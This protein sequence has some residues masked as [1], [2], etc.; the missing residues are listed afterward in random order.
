MGARNTATRL[1]ILLTLLSLL[2]SGS[3]WASAIGD[4]IENA[5]GRDSQAQGAVV[6]MPPASAPEVLLK[7]VR[8]SSRKQA[9]EAAFNLSVIAA[10]RG[11]L[12]SAATLIEEALLLAPENP[13]Y[14]RAAAGIAYTAGAYDRAE[15]YQL[16][17]L[18]MARSAYGP[19]DLR[20]ATL[21]DELGAVYFELNR[22][23]RTETLLRQGL[24]IREQGAGKMHP[25]L[26][27]TLNDLAGFAMQDGRFD[28]AEQLL[29]RA[30][31]ILEADAGTNLSNAAMAMHN[32]GDFY[33]NR[34]RFPEA[35]VLYRRA[36]LVWEGL[37]EEERLDVAASLNELGRFYAS[38]QRLDE[39]KPQFELV[40][41]LLS[42]DFGKD[43]SYVRTAMSGLKALAAERQRRVEAREFSQKM[44]DEL[45][46]QLAGSNSVN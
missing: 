42:S 38:Q 27:G 41:T 8:V 33:T 24:A 43:H 29:Q 6:E 32:L 5:P 18:E 46:A 19:D 14:L 26:A 28:E 22:Y 13:V 45:R 4:R 10:Q 3:S 23:A 15:A 16:R 34:K 30:L 20:L 9:A 17:V 35:Q 40:I 39:A 36:T 25:S 2:M 1:H 21:M 31:H 7:Q 44:F 37:P 11:E 12:V